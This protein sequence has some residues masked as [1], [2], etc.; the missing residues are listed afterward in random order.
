MRNSV[1][2]RTVC[3]A[4]FFLV[5]ACMVSTP[6][7]LLFG[8]SL[9][10][11]QLSCS[12]MG[13][14]QNRLEFSVLNKTIHP[15]DE[16]PVTIPIGTTLS[17]N[18]QPSL[19]LVGVAAK[20]IRLCDATGAELLFELNDA[21]GIAIHEG[22]LTPGCSLTLPV[23]GEPGKEVKFVIA[24]KNDLAWQLPD[25]YKVKG[26]LVNSGFEQGAKNVPS[27][28]RF[29]FSGGDRRIEWSSEKPY[30][31]SKCVKVVVN[32]DGAPSWISARQSGIRVK[33]GVTYR[34]GAWVKGQNVS[35]GCGWYV[36][37]GNRKNEMISSPMDMSAKGTFD[38]RK[39]EFE[40]KVPD[41]ADIISFGTVLY[42][43]GTAWF[44]AVSIEPT[45][46][47]ETSQWTVSLGKVETTPYPHFFFS[48][49]TLPNFTPAESLVPRGNR[50]A[51]FRLL[52]KVDAGSASHK[53]T[54]VLDATLLQNRWGRKLTANDVFVLDRTGRRQEVRQWNSFLFIETELAKKGYYY[55]LVVEQSGT[56]RQLQTVSDKSNT[57][58]EAFPG[59]AQQSNTDGAF[60]GTSQQVKAKNSDAASQPLPA[61]LQK[62]NLV[63][64]G[65]M[66]LPGPDAP[67]WVKNASTKG[68]HYRLVDPKAPFLGKQALELTVDKDVPISWRGSTQSVKVVPGRQYLCGLWMSCD[69]DG[70][71]Y[72]LHI[73]QRKANG[74]ISSG[75]MSSIGFGIGGKT[76]WTLMSSTIQASY[77][78]SAIQLHLTTAH[79]GTVRHDGVFLIEIESAAPVAFG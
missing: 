48:G 70:S 46:P 72:R 68:V 62:R 28:W 27:G 41:D 2:V 21:Q 64:N 6:R 43:T 10:N 57:S 60:P 4:V 53:T 24:F 22:L 44:D 79:S 35:G 11:D 71:D 55:F 36:H 45:T 20:S 30:K 47:V 29:D 39:V 26:K 61:E 54:V 76:D 3:A 37:V 63:Q 67:F 18:G 56:G 52:C 13:V 5:A 23:T 17:T 8:Q 1:F 40:F 16:T 7:S 9:W 74:E 59:T 49:Q 31:G 65:D 19:P 50:Y 33:S 32:P 78:T 75:G 58:G 14:W 15:F 73:H 42:G 25:W 12:G 66:E 77:D 38:W 69:S 51:L 34:F